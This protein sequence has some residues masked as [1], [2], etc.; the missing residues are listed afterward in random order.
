M[1]AIYSLINSTPWPKEDEVSLTDISEAL[2]KSKN[3]QPKH[4]KAAW[5]PIKGEETDLNR[6]F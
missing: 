6:A 4:K 2:E 5:L 3:D 1:R